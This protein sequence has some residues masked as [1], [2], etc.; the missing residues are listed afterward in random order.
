MN[1]SSDCDMKKSDSVAREIAGE[2]VAVFTMMA[3]AL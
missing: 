3:L 1:N 2:T